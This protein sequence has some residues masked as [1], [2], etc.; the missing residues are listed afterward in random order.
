[1]SQNVPEHLIVPL[2]L[3]YHGDSSD[4]PWGRPLGPGEFGPDAGIG[5]ELGNRS[6]LRLWLADNET[7]KTALRHECWMPCFYQSTVHIP[8]AIGDWSRGERREIRIRE[9]SDEVQCR[10][11]GGLCHVHEKNLALVSVA[12]FE[13]WG[14]DGD[15]CLDFEA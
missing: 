10:L 7:H 3:D 14:N 8:G 4:R 15:E 5:A 11:L 13:R 12:Y 1:M 9:D 6:L 2:G